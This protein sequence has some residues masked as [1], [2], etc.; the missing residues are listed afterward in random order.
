MMTDNGKSHQVGGLRLSLKGVTKAITP[1]G[2]AGSR[3][4]GRHG[5]D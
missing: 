4:R 1:E 3:L 2:F 5:E